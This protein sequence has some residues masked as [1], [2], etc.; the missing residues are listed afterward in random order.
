MKKKA[1]KLLFKNSNDPISQIEKLFF[2]MMDSHYYDLAKVFYEE[3]FDVI[4][5]GIDMKEKNN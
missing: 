4:N 5:Q 2:I 1:K 3:N